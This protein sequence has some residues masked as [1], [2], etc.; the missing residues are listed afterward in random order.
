LKQRTKKPTVLFVTD[1]Y[2]PAKSRDYYKEDLLVTGQLQADFDV[3]ICH[4]LHT[5]PFEE[6][7]DLVVIRNSGPTIY[8]Q[9]YFDAFKKRVVQKGI[10]TYNALTGRGDMAGKEYLLALTKEGYP[11]IPTIDRIEDL[12]C[13]PAT[14]RYI[15]KPKQ[16]ADSIGLQ[17]ATAQTLPTIHQDGY[18]IQPHVDFEYEVSFYFIDAAL[19]YALY[20]P[21]KNRR[22]QL[23]KYEPTAEDLLFAQRFIQWNT[24]AHGIQRVDA[25]RTK[26]G[27]LLLV[28]L[29]DLNPFLSLELLDGATQAQ[30]IANFKTALHNTIAQHN[31]HR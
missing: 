29:E 27:S 2:Y 25:C 16:G 4:P 23:E 24:I 26:E 22:W 30:F 7:V 14:D 28:E 31:N 20:A 6:L 15:V 21:D 3:L 18:L 17:H 19:Q 12:H 9:A 10:L 5:E 8:Y 1:L 13:L 11:V